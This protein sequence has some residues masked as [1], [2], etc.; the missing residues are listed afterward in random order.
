MATAVYS[1]WVVVAALAVHIA[2]WELS[3]LPRTWRIATAGC[4]RW[5]VVAP[6]D[7]RDTSRGGPVRCYSLDSRSFQSQSWHL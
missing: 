2:V 4:T 5:S 6:V 7:S 1:S 3:H